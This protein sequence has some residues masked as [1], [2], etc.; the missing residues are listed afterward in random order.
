[1][2]FATGRPL[3]GTELPFVFGDY[4]LDA[5]RRELRRGDA[6]VPLEPQVFDLLLHLIRNRDH[7]VSRDEL[8]QSVWGGR[9]VSESALASRITAVRKAIGDSGGRQERIRTIARKGIRFV[10][11]LV[12]APQASAPS[13][14]ERL[15]LALPD[16]PSIAVLPF[17]NMSGDVEQDYFADGMVEEITMALSRFHELF[18]IAR[19]SSFT[20]KGRAVDVKQVSRELGVRYVLEGSVR[21]SGQKVRITGQLIDATTGAHLWADR[22]DGTLDDVFDLQDRVTM[23]VVGVV[24]PRLLQAEIERTRLKPTESLDAYDHLLRGRAHFQTITRQ[25]NEQALI[26]LNQALALDPRF[27]AAAGLASTCYVHRRSQGWVGNVEDETR[28]GCRLARIVADGPRNDPLAMAFAASSLAYLGRD[29]DAGVALIEHALRLNTNSFMVWNNDGWIRTYIH[30]SD[31]AKTSFQRA[32]RLNPVD[33]L[34]GITLSGLSYA[35]FFLG[36]F[37]ESLRCARLAVHANPN[38]STSHIALIVALMATGRTQ[39][40]QVAVQDFLKIRPTYSRA[41]AR[42]HSVFQRPELMKEHSALLLEAGL[43]E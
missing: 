21:K 18:V 25:G 41:W 22:F 34:I 3:E 12:E 27:A 5:E 2:I 32:Y 13:A 11:E 38:F 43:P 10:A 4:A 39:D 6:L 29:Y 31:R 1:L 40:A 24:E 7:V 8:L 14:P 16:K 23:S 33:P 17:Q 37:E 15:A 35:H 19:N 26:H 9:I 36:E 30:D 28:E 42:Q 20:Y